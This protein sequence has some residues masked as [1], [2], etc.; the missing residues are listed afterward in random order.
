MLFLA[1][2]SGTDALIALAVI[3]GGFVVGSLAAAIARR[4]A[5]SSSSETV[6]SSAAA[7]AT[8]AFSILVIAALVAALGIINEAALDQLVS[9]I[10][11]F[12]PRLLS[13]T[14]VLIIG[15]IAGAIVETGVA[16]SLGHVSA[17]LRQ[18]VPLIVKWVIQAF[19]LVIAANQ[20]GIDT[21]IISVV[22]AAVSFGIALS[23]ALL[24]GLGGRGVAEQIAAGRALRRQ[25]K[26]GDTVRLGELH[27]EVKAIGSTAT[28]ITSHSDVV[29][30]PNKEFLNSSIE[31]LHAVDQAE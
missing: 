26:I 27:G 30:V 28:Q 21:T 12:M 9:D 20:L 17:E 8:L 31:I 14:I 25:L 3:V 24:A 10:I 13:A 18:R 15:N 11:T 6:Q 5:S 16:R 1:Q 19:V 4:V 23:F 29:F 22:V 7:L 2:T